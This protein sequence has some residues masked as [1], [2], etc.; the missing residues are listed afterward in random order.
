[1]YELNVQKMNCG[2]CVRSVTQAVQALDSAA[3]VEV[4]LAGKKV[5]VATDMGLD[6]VKSAIINAGYPVTEASG[7]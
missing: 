1:M 6:A 2:G 7:S 3:R 5:R 4:D